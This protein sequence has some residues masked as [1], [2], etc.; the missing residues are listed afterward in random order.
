MLALLGH[1]YAV[2]GKRG[3]AQKII[4]ELN[5]QSK[6]MY[7]DPY[8]LAQ[9]HTALGDRDKAFQELEKAYEEHSSWLVWLKVEPKFDSLRSD[10]RFTNLIQ[11][12]GLP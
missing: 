7:V 12:I 8:F 1:V 5:E 10:S 9:I 6:R 4:G 2:T 11:R 3:E